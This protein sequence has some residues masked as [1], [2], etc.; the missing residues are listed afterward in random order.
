MGPAGYLFHF[1]H[2]ILL[3]LILQSPALFL[4]S[5]ELFLMFFP[6]SVIYLFNISNSFPTIPNISDQ[7]SCCPIHTISLLYIFLAI[8]LCKTLHNIPSLLVLAFLYILLQTFPL[9]ILHSLNSP[10]VPIYFLNFIC[11]FLLNYC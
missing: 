6:P 4:F 7:T 5:P 2:S 11:F 1:L 3:P 9:S 8:V 10:L